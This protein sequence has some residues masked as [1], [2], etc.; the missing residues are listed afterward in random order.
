ME[1]VPA[2]IICNIQT[3]SESL[4]VI[5][6]TVDIANFESAPL[7]SGIWQNEFRR[8]ARIGGSP[9]ISR[10]SRYYGAEKANPLLIYA[11]SRILRAIDRSLMASLWNRPPNAAKKR[12]EAKSL[13][14]RCRIFLAGWLSGAGSILVVPILTVRI[15]SL[16][17]RKARPMDAAREDC[18]PEYK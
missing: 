6:D 13:S 18:A 5:R 10:K 2:A 1:E 3:A 15:R 4:E 8:F 12:A 14:C 16:T 17:G 7:A 11:R 9:Y